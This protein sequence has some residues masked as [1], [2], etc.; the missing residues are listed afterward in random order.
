MLDSF[1]YI[2]VIVGVLVAITDWRAG[3]N[4]A[5]IV[6]L[7]R[8]PV[9]KL[10]EG[11]P[12]AITLAGNSVLATVAL[13][14]W[15]RERNA[16]RC[17]LKWHPQVRA[18]F[19]MLCLA[20]A[21]GALVSATRYAGGWKLAAIGAISY[22][23]LAPGILIGYAFARQ[24]KNSVGFLA[25]FAVANLAMLTGVFLEYSGS[26]LPALGG[27]DS[28]W[29]RYY[30]S[31][32][33]SLI[34]GFYRSPDVMGWHAAMCCMASVILA[35]ERGGRWYFVGTV[36]FVALLLSGRRKM[37]ALPFVFGVLI[38]YQ[39]LQRRATGRRA[40]T[41]L[42][43]TV[44]TVLIGILLA[45]QAGISETYFD[46][47]GTIVAESVDRA[48]GGLLNA[49][50]TTIRQSGIFGAGL[51]TVTQGRQY[52]KDVTISRKEARLWQ[53][54]G[55]SRLFAELGVLGVVLLVG[56][57]TMVLRRCVASMRLSMRNA[58]VFRVQ[59]GVASM[60]A[61]NLACFVISHQTFSGDPTSACL[62]S[63]CLGIVLAS[64]ELVAREGQL[65]TWR[66]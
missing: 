7:L 32:V 13:V 63:F 31:S 23:A 59:S 10:S 29:I 17:M 39:Q 41:Y 52:V 62:A 2:V 16:L 53:E 35:R 43:A 4:F 9:R 55:V 36:A 1:Y 66:G 48:E 42:A 6:D 44:S 8:D 50:L 5:I 38:L 28:R 27:I 19:V 26:H 58:A 47:A 37:I 11:H 40:A 64:P 65:P 34:S 61:A 56:A 51:G 24:T 18:A 22:M 54:D 14:V 15:F 12:I 21:P 45:S 49:S 25:F 46:Y 57:V 20:M 60:L 33:I 30:G 3:L